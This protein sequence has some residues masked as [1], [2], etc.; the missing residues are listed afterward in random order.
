MRKPTLTI[1]FLVAFVLVII[2]LRDP[3]HEI[4]AVSL[5]T[6]FIVYGL[7]EQYRLAKRQIEGDFVIRRQKVKIRL[8]LILIVILQII[9]IIANDSLSFLKFSSAFLIVVFIIIL[10]LIVEKYKPIIL[11]VNGTSLIA[12]YAQTVTHDLTEL[13]KLKLLGFS[14]DLILTFKS[15][16]TVSI[17]RDEY[18]DSDIQKLIAICKETSQEQLE[19]SDNLKSHIDN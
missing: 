7:V 5:I 9:S 16:K 15:G 11:A 17:N 1:L 14:N 10:K 19:V 6:A 4:V 13:T 12:N 18:L 2:L 3:L 8:S